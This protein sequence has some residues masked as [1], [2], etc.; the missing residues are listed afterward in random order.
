M[1]GSR[2]TMAALGAGLVSA[3][4]GAAPALAEYY[5]LPPG[6]YRQECRG[7]RIIYGYLLVAH[8]PKRNG[9]MRDSSLDL[10]TCPRGAAV[11]NDG[12]Y[13]KCEG[14]P[15][16]Q[17]GSGGGFPGFNWGGSGGSYNSGYRGGSYSLPP[18]PY[19]HECRRER[20]EN[21]YMLMATCPKRNGE[22]RDSSLDLRTCPRGASVYNDGA[23]LR[24]S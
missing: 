20:V 2:L 23:Y 5:S 14:Q 24:C 11:V 9:E 7:E 17:G 1:L 6:P 12:A 21:G 22:M 16:Y 4:L 18:G 19:R 13:L 3:T 10:R 15:A 8:C